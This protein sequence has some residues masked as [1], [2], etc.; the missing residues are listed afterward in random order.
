M[1]APDLFLSDLTPDEAAAGFAVRRVDHPDGPPATVPAAVHTWGDPS[2]R[3]VKTRGRGGEVVFQLQA[4]GRRRTGA[5]PVGWHPERYWPG[6]YGPAWV[7]ERL[8]E[9]LDRPRYAALID[10]HVPADADR[11]VPA[12]FAAVV[13]AAH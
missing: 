3:L 13:A 10:L 8:R 4:F 11:A 6:R 7:L 12:D 1:S 9:H 5:G 2:H